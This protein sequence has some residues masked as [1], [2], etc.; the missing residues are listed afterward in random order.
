MYEAH[1]A[2]ICIGQKAYVEDLKKDLKNKF[3]YCCHIKNHY[4]NGSL[5]KRILKLK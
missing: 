5:V 4:K 2:Y 1:D 3:K